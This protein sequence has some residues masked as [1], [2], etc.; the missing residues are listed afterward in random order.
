MNLLR[1]RKYCRISPF[2]ISTEEGRAAERYRLAFLSVIA[3]VI[4]RAA[5]MAVMLVSVKVTIPYL[6]ADRFGIWM[7]IASIVG[8]LSFM[9]LGLGNALANRV[10]SAAVNGPLSGLRRVVSGGLAL[11]LA[12]SLLIS[13]GLQVFF[14][15]FPWQGLIKVDK[16]VDVLEVSQALTTLSILFGVSIFAGGVHRVFAGLQRAYQAHLMNLVFSLI[17]LVL[18]LAAAKH[19]AGIPA[20]IGVTLGVQVLSGVCLFLI[21][22]GQ[23]IFVLKDI[24]ASSL[25][26]R[27]DILKVGGL[28]FVLQVGG[29]VAAGADNLLIMAFHGAGQVA[30]FNIGQRLFQLVSQPLAV[31]NAPLWAAYADAHAR[32]DRAFIGMTLK[33]SMMVTAAISF[34]GGGLVLMFGDVLTRWWTG[35]AVVMPFGLGL[36]F[37]LATICEAVGNA[38]AMM[39]NGCGIVRE[40][41]VTVVMLTVLALVVKLVVLSHWGIT[42]MLASYA[43]AYCTVV[44]SMYG[45]VY[46][47]KLT[48]F[49]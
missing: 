12:L 19:Q 30:V 2:D 17:S 7:T 28:F 49:M 1:M 18:V 40:Q 31:M 14:A 45:L 9:D 23:R 34:L 3:N 43:V 22:V 8:L 4:S 5:G 16:S 33:R 20:L 13:L 44:V 15:I 36:V 24:V 10:S 38:L 41:V 42:E 47:K 26:E 21:L 35:G 27:H 46:R 11:L 37:F 6:G 25:A 29:V 48:E 39:L 32:G